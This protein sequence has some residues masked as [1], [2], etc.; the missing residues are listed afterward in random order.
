MIYYEIHGSGAPLLLIAGLASDS[1]SWMGVVPELS[2]HFKVIIFDNRG[3]GRSDIP[4]EPYSI[5]DLA[6]DAVKL[7][8]SLEIKQAHVLGHSMGGYIVQEMAIN[9][10]ER[11]N[12]LVL[13]STSFVSSQRNNRIFADLLKQLQTGKSYEEWIHSW[14]N[15]MFSEKT[16]KN[17]EF[18]NAFIKGAVAYPYHSSAA[19]FKGQVEAIVSFNAQERVKEIKAKTLVLEGEEDRLIPPEEARA[20]ADKIG[21][22]SFQLFKQTGHS[23]CIENPG[24]FIESVLKFIKQRK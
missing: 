20:L 17:R 14:T 21:G 4:S 23:V 24:K 10:P 16:L 9:Y 13:A 5:R 19:G 2:K 7:L 15:W 18:I 8:D 3:C 6:D 1:A 12:K 11:V 22:S